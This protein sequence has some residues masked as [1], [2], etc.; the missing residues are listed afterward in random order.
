ML[1]DDFHKLSDLLFAAGD[2]YR[3][4]RAVVRHR[5]RGDLATEA[6]N[7][8]TEY[9]FSH[10][11]LSNFDPPYHVPRYREY[12]DLEET[13]RLWHERP[14]RWRQ[15]TDSSDSLETEYRVA[16]GKGPWWYY[17]VP[18]HAPYRAHYS[19]A[20]P[21]GEFTPDEKLSCLLDPFQVRYGFECTLKIVGEAQVMSRKSVE[22]R[23][24]AI[25]WDYAPHGPFWDGADDYLMS[26]DAEIGVIL[27][28]A[29]RL[30]GEEL[31]VFE[32]VELSFDEAFPP[33]TFALDLPGVEFER[34]DPMS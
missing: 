2:R 31:D 18:D 4:A 24:E 15:E 27:R 3:T 6:E 16:D 12:G 19:P 29:S 32:M 14:D 20:N 26:V 8:Y 22:V 11:I 17:G 30:R 7:R 1:D 25:S 9:G 34:V 10:G 23:A 21:R 33:G 5:R 28:F 13:S